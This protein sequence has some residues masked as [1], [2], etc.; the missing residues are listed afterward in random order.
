MKVLPIFIT[1]IAALF[2]IVACSNRKKA[3]IASDSASPSSSEEKTPRVLV[4]YFSATGTTR[5]VAERIAAATDGDLFE[6]A[7]EVPYTSADLDWT[8]DSSRSSLE[9]KQPAAS[10]PA[11]KSTCD[12]IACYD[13][14]YI[15]FPIWWYTNPTIVN[16]FIESCDLKGKKLIPFATSGGST[17]E[18]SCEDLK[19]NYPDYEWA[20]GKLLNNPTDEELTAWTASVASDK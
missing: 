14:V 9:M 2:L 10:R 1:F 4:A 20:E 16:T 11:L 3:Q 15:G 8:N 19:K 13:I 17:I 6:I 12:K 18:K 7:P 5:R